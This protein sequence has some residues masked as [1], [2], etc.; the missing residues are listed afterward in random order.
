MKQLSRKDALFVLEDSP[1]HRRGAFAT[2][3]IKK[4]TV[5]IEYAGERIT[6]EEA[7]RREEINALK[8]T[9]YVMV[10]DDNWC[11]DGE[12]NGNESQY[13]NHSCEPNCGIVVLKGRV[14][15][16]ALRNIRS[17]EELTYDYAFPYDDVVRDPCRCGSRSCRG[18]I[19]ELPCEDS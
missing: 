7:K 2:R 11:I 8:G 12:V 1:I 10:L 18:F 13:I 15:V 14:F 17:G 16:S 6:F 19:Q 4:G 9:T 5:I 3:L